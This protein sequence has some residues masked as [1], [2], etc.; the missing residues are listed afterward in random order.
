MDSSAKDRM[1]MMLAKDSFTTSFSG[2]A[3][4]DRTAQA[5][6]KAKMR[7]GVR[8]AGSNRRRM[9]SH[10]ANAMGASLACLSNMDDSSSWRR[11]AAASS[12]F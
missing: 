11:S 7:S 1:S 9:A 12:N 5:S 6:H 3:L 8:S 10:G 2:E 4:A